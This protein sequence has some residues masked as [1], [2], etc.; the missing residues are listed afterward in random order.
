MVMLSIERM[1]QSAE[2]ALGWPYVSPGSNSSAGIDCSGLFVKIYRDQGSSIYHGSNRIFRKFCC[3][4]GKIQSPNQLMAGMA[5]FKWKNRRPAGY[6]D[7][8]GDFVHIGLVVSTSPL[9]II[10]ASSE[11]GCVTTDTAIGKWTYWGKLSAVYYGKR[12]IETIRPG[13]PLP[14]PITKATVFAKSGSTVKMRVRPSKNCRLYEEVPI[15]STVTILEE[16][17][18]WSKISYGNR[19]GWYMMTKFLQQDNG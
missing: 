13:D 9:K 8:L 4:T 11:K 12:P 16:G 3:E 1:I 15:G 5:V 14:N 6:N 17:K 19:K 2:E 10:H 7:D 18:T